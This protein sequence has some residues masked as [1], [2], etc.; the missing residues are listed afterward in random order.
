MTETL[1]RVGRSKPRGT[2]NPTNLHLA[3]PLRCLFDVESVRIANNNLVGLDRRLI[4]LVEFLR[5]DYWIYEPYRNLTQVVAHL[6]GA[7]ATLD[8]ANP[9]H[10]SLFFEAA[11]LYALAITRAA[12]HVRTTRIGD[13]PGATRTFVAGG[14]LATRKKAQL[15][16]LLEAAGIAVGARAAVLPPYMDLLI[17]LSTRF[18]VQPREPAEVLRY[19]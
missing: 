13:V 6:A 10:L 18:V 4:G 7:V 9:R 5:F 12:H 15:A 19:A 14:E 8:P 3:G 11:W 1:R 2:A 16:D 17:Q